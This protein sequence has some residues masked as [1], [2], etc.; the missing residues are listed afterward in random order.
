M[1][2]LTTYCRITAVPKEVDLKGYLFFINDTAFGD[3]V[4]K[5]RK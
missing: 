5:K 2:L 4:N 3:E 1:K